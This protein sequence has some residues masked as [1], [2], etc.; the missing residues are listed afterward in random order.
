LA[1]I[2]TVIFGEV[3]KRLISAFLVE[4]ALACIANIPTAICCGQVRF[5]LTPANRLKNLRHFDCGW[6]RRIQNLINFLVVTIGNIRQLASEIM[7]ACE[8][9]CIRFFLHAV[10]SGS[11]SCQLFA[12]VEHLNKGISRLTLLH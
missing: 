9:S 6:F 4:D 11:F 1:H 3:S 8:C 10:F 7:H 2:Y 12:R 5:L